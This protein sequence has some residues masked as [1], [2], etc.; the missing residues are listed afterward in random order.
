MKQSSNFVVVLDFIFATDCI[1][2]VLP[3]S[4][5]DMVTFRGAEI[6]RARGASESRIIRVDNTPHVT[7]EQSRAWLEKY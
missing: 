3:F 6:A 1:F 4:Q 5:L 2:F 7:T